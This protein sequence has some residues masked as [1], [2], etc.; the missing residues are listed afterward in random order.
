MNNLKNIGSQVLGAGRN[1]YFAGLGVAVIGG[2][3]TV[4]V[5]NGLVEK[6]RV[7]SEKK[8][9]CKATGTT[10]L[11]NKIAG[12]GKATGERVQGGINGVLKRLGIPSR[13]EIRDLT[14]SV[15]Q[16]TEKVSGLQTK[17]AE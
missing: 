15:T 14:R 4:K 9:T 13:D 11:K 17:P 2:D 16:L 12:L 3:R 1:L 6:G 10:Q 7:V 5:F 8:P